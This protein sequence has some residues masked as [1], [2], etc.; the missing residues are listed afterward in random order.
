MQNDLNSANSSNIGVLFMGKEF[1]LGKPVIG[2]ILTSTKP[3][4]VPSYQRDYSWDKDEVEDFW[5][6]LIKCIGQKSY[7]L[8]S[9]VFKAEKEDDTIIV[10]DGQQRLATITILLSAIRDLLFKNGAQR[11]YLSISDHYIIKEYEGET[12]VKTLTLNL[13]NREYFYYCIQLLPDD[14]NRKQFTDYTKTEKTNKLIKNAYLFFKEEISKLISAIS[15]KEKIQYLNSLVTHI[16]TVLRVITITVDTEEEA[17]LIFETINDRGLELS[18]ADLFKN[19]LI[20]KAKSDEDKD[21]IISMWK[22]I[23]TL[24]DDKLRAFLRH[25]WVSKKGEITERRLFSELTTHIEDDNIDVKDFVKEM[26]DEAINYNSIYNPEDGS[27]QDKEISKLIYEFNILSARQCLPLL[28]SGLEMFDER[29]FKNLLG[30]VINFTFRYSTICNRHNNVLETKYS[31]TAI[32]MRNGKIKDTVNAMKNLKSI[33]PEKAEFEN[34]FAKK[35]VEGKLGRYILKKIDEEV[36]QY[37]GEKPDYNSCTLEHIIPQKPDEDWKKFFTKMKLKKEDID[38]ATYKIG[39]VTLLD[40]GLNK[41]AKNYFF[42]KKRDESYKNSI[43][44][45]NQT[46]KG[47][48]GWDLITIEQRQRQLAELANKIWKID[49]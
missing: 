20:R 16:R 2:D 38:E 35:K 33:Y 5:K 7:F 21:E 8:G 48:K 46:L 10:I 15:P 13:L 26:K 3:Y 45:I 27:W 23:S 43:L 4:I 44:W 29:E 28:L 14:K 31:D 18:V 1:E 49:F 19:Y 42:I 40:E 39:N 22:E 11:D 25:Y 24:L 12:E 47:I 17:Y 6:D 32:Q 9:M 41:K 34:M 36:G 30:A 37:K